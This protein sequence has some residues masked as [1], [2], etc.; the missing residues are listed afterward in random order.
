PPALLRALWDALQSG[1][2]DFA[3]ASRYIPGGGTPVWPRRRR[4]MSRLACWLA[5]PLTDVRDPTSGFFLVRR[6]LVSDV[7][8]SSRGFKIG[9]ELLVRTNSAK[10]VEVPYTFS[11]RIVGRSKMTLREGLGYL[12][13][14]CRLSIFRL[15]GL[16]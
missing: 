10:I 1:P 11:D 5:R 6:S 9:L 8:I 13:Q 16:P 7:T 3:I 4:F 14:V 2:Y 15:R 12:A